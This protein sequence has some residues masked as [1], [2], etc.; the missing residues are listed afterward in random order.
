MGASTRNDPVTTQPNPY[1]QGLDMPALQELGTPHSQSAN[2]ANLPAISTSGQ[3]SGS[4]V[5]PIPESRPPEKK[6]PGL[7]PA[8]DKKYF[9][10][11][12]K[13]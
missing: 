2:N 11:L 7:V 3:A 9:P 13:F 6:P 5:T 10:Q 8:D 12:R 1:L 4:M